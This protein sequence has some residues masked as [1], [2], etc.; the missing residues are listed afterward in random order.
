[1]NDMEQILKSAVIIPKELLS[2]VRFT[3]VD[4]LKNEPVRHR[5]RNHYLKKAESVGNLY[6]SK[7]KIY[8]KT[9]D[10][11]LMAVET[12]IWSAD[13]EFVTVKGGAIPTH[14]IWAVD[15]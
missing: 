11:E 10:L 14:S 9:S 2:Q 8:F 1:M 5:L 4:V 13:E 12:T 15:F 7:V 6:K 3:K